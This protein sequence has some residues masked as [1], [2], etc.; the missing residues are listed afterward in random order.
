[1]IVGTVVVHRAAAEPRVPAG[2]RAA[3]G[4]PLGALASPGVRSLILTSLPAGIGIGICE[5]ALPAFT[6]AEGAAELAGLLLAIWSLGSAAG[7]LIYG[8]LPNRP[9]LG[10]VHLAVSALLPLGLLPLALAPSVAVMARW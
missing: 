5:V 2:P 7:G 4:R 9:P 3:H 10:R 6:D 1:M 8:A